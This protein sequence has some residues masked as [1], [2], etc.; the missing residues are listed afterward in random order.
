MKLE[1]FFRPLLK[2]NRSPL[3]S[4]VHFHVFAS[5]HH[6]DGHFPFYLD[7]AIH[8][9]NA[10]SSELD[11]HK[12]CQICTGLV[13]KGF[14]ESAFVLRQWIRSDFLDGL[15]HVLSLG[16]VQTLNILESIRVESDFAPAHS[17][18]TSS[19]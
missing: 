14:T 8:N 5:A 3:G 19:I 4:S 15:K 7:E 10:T 6:D 2:I 13:S 18:S 1:I 9:P 12:A 16:A 11:F 17:N